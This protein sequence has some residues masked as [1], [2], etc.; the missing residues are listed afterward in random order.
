MRSPITQLI[1]DFQNLTP[2]QQKVFL[3]LVDP[4]P[5]PQPVKRTRKK[6]AAAPTQQKRGLPEPVGALD[7]AEAKCGT[8]G[9]AESFQDHFKPSPNYHEFDVPKPRRKRKQTVDSPALIPSSS[10]GVDGNG[11]AAE[12]ES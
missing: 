11:L 12:M 5:E 4:Q 3:D 2:D 6:R 10:E 8:C 9:N 7:E 1:Q